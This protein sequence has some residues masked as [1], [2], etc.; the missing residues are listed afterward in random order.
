MSTEKQ[1]RTYAFLDMKVIKLRKDKSRDK[2][3]YVHANELFELGF[4]TREETEEFWIFTPT[5]AGKEVLKHIQ[6]PFSG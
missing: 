2:D 4:L 6:D 3:L 5:A 1:G